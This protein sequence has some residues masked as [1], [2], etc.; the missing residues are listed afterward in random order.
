MCRH[1]LPEK[2]PPFSKLKNVGVFTRAEAMPVRDFLSMS[3]LDL[4]IP[5][6]KSSVYPEVKMK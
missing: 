2:L 6:I 4:F 3:L 1:G 5:L